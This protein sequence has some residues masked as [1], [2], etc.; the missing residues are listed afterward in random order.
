MK[1]APLFCF[2]MF[3]GLVA[4]ATIGCDNLNLFT[5]TNNAGTT[6]TPT[7]N[8]EEPAGPPWPA[9]HRCSAESDCIG[10]NTGNGG[11]NNESGFCEQ[12]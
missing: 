10:W 4:V 6:P 12:W 9:G 3:I 7:P 5:L 8:P 2:L 11:C 1:K